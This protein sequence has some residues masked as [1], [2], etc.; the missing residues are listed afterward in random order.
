[1]RKN[2]SVA[3]MISAAIAASARIVYAD[4]D[5]F[6]TRGDF[7]GS[8][9]IIANGFQGF[10][11][12]NIDSD[13]G[14]IGQTPTAASLQAGQEV[15]FEGWG[16]YDSAGDIE[17]PF[18]AT[19]TDATS[20][21]IKGDTVAFLSTSLGNASPAT[22]GLGHYANDT[23]AHTDEF[24]DGYPTTPA[25]TPPVLPTVAA[26]F[27][28]AGSDPYLGRSYAGNTGTSG[29]M[30]VENYQ[31]FNNGAGI[32][33][34]K[35]STG[36][37]VV[38][39][40]TF[41]GATS[42]APTG[43]SAST[44]A[45][46]NAI[47]NSYAM[48][49][50]FSAPGGGTTLTSNGTGS[51]GYYLL[52][53]STSDSTTST[54][55]TQ[56]GGF[57]PTLFD[58]VDA[59]NDTA[60]NKDVGSFG[61][62]P[63]SFVV[64][65]GTGPGSYWTAYLPY[66]YSAAMSATFLQMGIELNMDHFVGGNVTIDNIRTVSPTW[67]AP[68][69]G[70]W[71]TGGTLTPDTNETQGTNG[72]TITENV[73]SEEELL[74]AGGAGNWI[75]AKSTYVPTTFTGANADMNGVT[76]TYGLGVP[77]GSGVSVTFGD[78]ISTAATVTLDGNKTVGTLN[79]NNSVNA[80]TIAQGS[81]GSLIL[82]NGAN[83]AAIND[84]AGT[85]TISAPITLNSNTA[86]TVTN[87][88]DT[89]NI[90]GTL[91]ASNGLTI[92]G[93]GKVDLS[94]AATISGGLTNTGYL[95]ISDT[96]LTVNGGV[97]NSGTMEFT[98]A[99]A[100]FNG[101][102]ILMGTVISDPSTLSFQNLTIES[103]ASFQ[104]AA[105]DTI[106]VSGNLVNNGALSG[107]GSLSVTGTVSGTGPL[108]V[109]GSSGSSATVTVAG[110]NQPTVTIDSTGTLVVNGGS[111]NN[112]N[113]L[114]INGGGKLDLTNG[115]LFINYGTGS[116]PITQIRQY[117]VSGYNGGAWNGSGI[118]SSTAAINHNYGVGYADGAD[119]VVPGL[120][121]GQIEVKYTLLGD[122]NLDGIVSGDDFT[123]LAGNLGKS[124]SK[125]D[126]GDFNYDGL[127]SGEDFTA[128]VSN[129]GKEANGADVTLPA[130]DLAAIDAFAA[131]N[132]L[133]AD[134]PEPAS[135]GLMVITSAGMLARRRRR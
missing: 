78:I 44:T 16:S 29:S 93:A 71:N 119:N 19:G 74:G 100:V 134:V 104:S 32:G 60:S 95:H 35:I 129:I 86:I 121:S 97:T 14:N 43:K 46:L 17:H 67:A 94:A 37:M 116:D 24:G 96:T 73:N 79:F 51:N 33:F 123:I 34:T 128:L 69:G 3:V 87:A 88:A 13:F 5:L 117:L 18:G 113:T 112:V 20:F 36:E 84:L 53:F 133:L 31:P 27:N 26:P 81:G 64:Q 108:T 56:A 52:G 76:Q 125:W 30:V 15:G 59:V 25:V 48:A 41:P 77:N 6:S 118:D 98:G 9:S 114:T 110:L 65:H 49:I 8:T 21:D 127:V 42:I 92:A 91:G 120:S 126:K 7:G 38:P 83:A 28:A 22:N 103:N 111:S 50:D 124:V 11:G 89:L 58:Y 47:A 62:E 2:K 131:A 90:S 54:P 45:F 80:Y 99:N 4:T 55:T 75:G 105:G 66:G 130:A 85:H 101:T 10:V 106:T 12:G 135:V 61:D 122:A 82:D 107:G 39:N 68:G 57:N 109:G 72:F 63:G 115:H 23:S 40:T 132:G 1:M 70:S 102:Y